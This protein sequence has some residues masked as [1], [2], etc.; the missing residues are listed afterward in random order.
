MA[1]PG[2]HYWNDLN[3]WHPIILTHFR[4]KS[5]SSVS[6][7]E[8]T[9]RGAA[10]HPVGLPAA[11]TMAPSADSLDPFHAASGD[12]VG[13]SIFLRLKDFG[14]C[15]GKLVDRVPNRTRKIGGVQVNFIAEFDIDKGAQT[16]LAL[17]LHEYDTSPSADYESWLLLEPEPSAVPAPAPAASA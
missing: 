4:Y 11:V 3:E 6:F 16:D 1:R 13:T 2:M 9:R 15:L 5:R 17:E 8:E 10:D 7:S 14:W 12:L